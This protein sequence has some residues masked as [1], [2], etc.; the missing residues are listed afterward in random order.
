MK[1]ELTKE[2]SQHLID[3]G[4]P[5]KMASS[6]LVESMEQVYGDKPRIKIF[7][8]T[9]LLEMLPKVIRIDAKDE[10]EYLTKRIGCNGNRPYYQTI[11]Y[12]FYEKWT[13]SYE[14]DNSLNC[15]CLEYFVAEECID[16]LYNMAVWCIKNGFIKFNT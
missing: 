7:T 4:V 12:N 14:C 5:E 15:G 8:Q 10:F 11:K 16:A 3:L 1:T 13:I 9:D 2:Q 6:E